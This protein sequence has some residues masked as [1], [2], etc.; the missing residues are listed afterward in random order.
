MRKIKFAASN[1]LLVMMCFMF[2]ACPEPDPEPDIE[3]NLVNTLKM[4]KWEYYDVD[5]FTDTDYGGFWGSYT[6]R[7]YFMD[8]N[9]GYHYSVIKDYDSSL[10]NSQKTSFDKFTYSVSG[11]TV[12]LN[13]KSGQDTYTYRN[14]L[15]VSSSESYYEP[16]RMTESDKD[17]VKRKAQEL[18][19]DEENAEIS[20]NIKD[21]VDITYEYVKEDMCIE[22]TIDTELGKEFPGKTFKYGIEYGYGDYEYTSYCEMGG[23]SSRTFVMSILFAEYAIYYNSYIALREKIDDGEKLDDSEQELLEDVVYYLEKDVKKFKARYFV[24]YNGERFYF[25]AYFYNIKIDLDDS[26]NN[27]NG[28]GNTNDENNQTTGTIQGHSY[29]DLGLSVKWATCNVGA[30]KPEDYGDHYDW[31]ETDTKS[32]YSD[33]TYKWCKGTDDT[34]TKYCTDS[35]YGTVDNRTTL[36]SSDDVATVKWGSKWRMPTKEEMKELDEDCTWTWT[37]Q[38]GVKGMKVTGPNGNSIFL[39]AAG[40][41]IDTDLCYRGS[42]GRYWSAT[43]NESNSNY[44]CNLRFGSGYSYLYYWGSR[45]YSGFSVRP[46]T[47]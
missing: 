33:K 7:L 46:V 31:G 4:Y 5:D 36:T 17:F 10:G 28:G 43:L 32:K 26:Y 27:S 3:E 23:N 38:N 39:P 11:N 34:M 19:E 35:E 37:T 45:G 44:A 6:Y 30:S 2:A 40:Y 20:S 1:L 12:R 13:F 25:N 14:G 29:V 9:V 16:S 41:R 42:D 24:E 18:E 8:N 21:Y 47:E 15:L 22:F